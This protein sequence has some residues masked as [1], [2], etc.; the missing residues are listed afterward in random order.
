MQIY[1]RKYRQ[2]LKAEEL[3]L[4]DSIHMLRIGNNLETQQINLVSPP[5]PKI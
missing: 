2:K 3:N 4:N 5:H 1:I